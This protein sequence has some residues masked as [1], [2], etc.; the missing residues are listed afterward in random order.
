VKCKLCNLEMTYTGGTSNMLNY[1]KLKHSSDISGWFTRE[2]FC[3]KESPIM[4]IFNI[5]NTRL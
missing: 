1:L 4:A 5:H 2:R 3:M